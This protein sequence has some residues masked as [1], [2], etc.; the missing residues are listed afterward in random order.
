MENA[1]Y[2]LW[3]CRHS[4]KFWTDVCKFIILNRDFTF[5]FEN[6]L[7]GF[8]GSNIIKMK[9]FVSRLLLTRYVGFA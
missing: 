4:K 8:T 3:N 1:F 7:F 2:L 6:V 9:V 5:T